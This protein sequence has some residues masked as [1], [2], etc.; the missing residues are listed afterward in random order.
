LSASWAAVGNTDLDS[1]VPHEDE[2]ITFSATLLGYANGSLDWTVLFICA[3][4]EF[5]KRP[6]G[7]Y[8][9]VHGCPVKLMKAST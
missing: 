9:W 6:H 3:N 1:T 2:R 5:S 8:L 4:R 7:S